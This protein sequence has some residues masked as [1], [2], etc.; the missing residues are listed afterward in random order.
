MVNLFEVGGSVRD[1]LLGIKNH[2]QDF[3]FVLDK[4]EFEQHQAISLAF[5]FMEQW[6][7]EQGFRLFLKSPEF[8]TI[9]AK[10]PPPQERL[11]SDFVL[12]RKE[13]GY[14]PGT[15]QPIAVPGTLADDLRRRDF[16]INAIAIMFGIV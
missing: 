14:K 8:L 10:F 16:T 15:R 13:L 2:D 7:L 11:V 4:A 6:L 3:I 9:R 12:A 1:G 5:S